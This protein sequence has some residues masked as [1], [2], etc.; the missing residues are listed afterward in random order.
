MLSTNYTFIYYPLTLCDF[1]SAQTI[2]QLLQL[3]TEIVYLATTLT[4]S[5]CRVRAK[6]GIQMQSGN[7]LR[8]KAGVGGQGLSRDQGQCWG[9]GQVLV[10]SSI[11]QLFSQF[12][13]FC[14]VQMQN[15]NC[16]RIRVRGLGLMSGL[17]L[18]LGSGLYFFCR[19]IALFPVLYAFRICTLQFRIIPLSIPAGGT[20]RQLHLL[21]A[22]LFCIILVS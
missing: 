14:I 2:A 11:A 16:I 22:L 6:C 1:V 10:C 21:R 3:Q 8:V 5:S 17:R 12:Y 9:H 15:G 20:R 18:A 13:A 19:S 4:T 7:M